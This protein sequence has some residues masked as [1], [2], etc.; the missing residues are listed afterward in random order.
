MCILFEER[1]I[2]RLNGDKMNQPVMKSQQE[3]ISTFNFTILSISPISLSIQ[4]TSSHPSRIGC[5]AILKKQSIS[6]NEISHSK[7]Q[8]N[9][10]CN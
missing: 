10:N 8:A 6:L 5:D 9:V 2:N 1:L 4:L 3:E 7:Y